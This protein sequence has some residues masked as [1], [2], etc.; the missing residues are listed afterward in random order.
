MKLVT[1]ETHGARHIGAMLPD[2]RT[3]SDFTASAPSQPH[4]KD[5]LALIDG[6]AGALDH[7]AELSRAPKTTVAL[8]DV[9]LLAPVPQPRQMRDFLCFELHLRQARASRVMSG[10]G[11]PA[12]P[13]T[14]ELPQV[15]YEQPIYY[16]CN[17]FSVIGT[18]QDVLWPRYCK[19]LDYEL[20]FGAILGKGGKNIRREDARSHIFGYCIFNDMSARDAQMKEMQGQLGP[21]KG[22]DFDTG[23]ILGPWLVTAD[24]ITDPDNLTMVARVNGEEWSRGNSG[25]MKHKFEDI[26][27][28]ASNEET[29][30]PGEF[31]GSGTVGNGC[32]LELGRFLKPGDVIELEIDGLGLLRNRVVAQA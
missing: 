8:S 1:F 25:T 16:K 22:K 11:E 13:A 26:L 10:G 24:E 15:W 27:V 4:F 14:I 7:A 32:G 6:G 17:R 23:N 12:D 3:I 9:R 31:F 29:L 2:G 18:G 28:H 5:M 21:A 20:E 30:Y 19:L